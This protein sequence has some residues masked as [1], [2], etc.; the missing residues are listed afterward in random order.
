MVRLA[1]IGAGIWG[2]NYIKTISTLKG[3][4]LCWV[5]DNNP[6]NLLSLENKYATILHNWEEKLDINYLDGVILATKAPLLFQYAMKVLS[7]GL[8]IMIEKPFTLNLKDA[9]TLSK[10]IRESN[11]LILV[12]HIYLFHPAYEK[13]KKMIAKN[14]KIIS[15]TS[16]GSNWGPFRDEVSALW[17]WSPHDLSLCLDLLGEYPDVIK[18]IEYESINSPN[19]KG[20]M[21]KI[22]M[23]FP[24]GTIVETK[25][26]N[27]SKNKN[28]IFKVRLKDRE[29]YFNDAEKNKLIEIKNNNLK[30]VSISKD[31]P[32][33]RAIRLFVSGINGKND[34]RFGCNLGL[35]IT[36]IISTIETKINQMK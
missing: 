32:L 26:G 33:Y 28:R 31:L 34:S 5:A 15:I 7:S 24:S 16:E 35:Q 17:D 14:E 10:K 36:N 25:V 19:K 12:N 29:L 1:L 30:P 13:I 8:P 6:R 4:E 3:V 18:V 9:N 27:I 2:Q 20:A 11:Q 23:T 22:F 21:I